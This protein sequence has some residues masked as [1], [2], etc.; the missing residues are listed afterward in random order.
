[1]PLE[2]EELMQMLQRAAVLSRRS[3]R[4]H[5][6][7]RIGE[8][9]GEGRGKSCHADGHRGSRN[10]MA[11]DEEATHGYGNHKCHGGSG[12]HGQNRV[13]A[14]LV[15]SDGMSQK[16][17]A[18]ILGIRPQSLSEA[19]DKLEESKLVE[20]RQNEND[21][22]VMNV[23]LT[24]AGRVRASKVAEDRKKSANDVFGIL[25]DEEKEQYA[26]IMVKII[27]K[28]DA[29]LSEKSVS[30]IDIDGDDEDVTEE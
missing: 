14:V 22:R 17:L 21:K 16:D 26:S 9:G 13:L 19:L 12:R 24:E 1:M 4:A 7:R 30:K 11:F 18:Y 6:K 2:N 5:V 8:Q 25:T 27:T 20:R 28:L 3:R 15:L 23:Y 10:A 29:D